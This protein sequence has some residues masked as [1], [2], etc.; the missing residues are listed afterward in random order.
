VKI[1]LRLVAVIGG[2]SVALAASTTVAAGPNASAGAPYSP[3]PRALELAAAVAAAT[4]DSSRLSAVNDA[5]IDELVSRLRA[6]YPD[7]DKVSRSV[8]EAV[9]RDE[10]RR[11]EDRFKR[12]EISIIAANFTEDQLSD[13]VTFYKSP[14]GRVLVA[15]T[16]AIRSETDELSHKIADTIG[17]EAL[18]ATCAKMG[19]RSR[20]TPGSPIEGRF[21]FAGDPWAKRPSNLTAR[22]ITSSQ[23]AAGGPYRFQTADLRCRVGKQG[24]LDDCV[25]EWES[26]R[27]AG[28]GELALK[29]AKQSRLQARML[30]GTDPEGLYVQVTI[31][32]APASQPPVPFL[33]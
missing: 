10:L 19:C 6:S 32:L 22:P 3:S 21:A 9:V 27:N 13:L 4:D 26:L 15:L 12:D 2:V 16:P 25:V 33:H 29:A 1:P 18:V 24:R 8:L 31:M 7:G 30:D 5:N 11:G 14:T 28:G 17:P 20:P 23:S